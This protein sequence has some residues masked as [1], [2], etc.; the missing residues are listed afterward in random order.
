MKLRIFMLCILSLFILS[1]ESQPAIDTQLPKSVIATNHALTCDRETGFGLY[2][3]TANKTW[4]TWSGEDMNAYV[5]EYDHTLNTW[6]PVQVVGKIPN[7]TFFQYNWSEQKNDYHNY[8]KITQMANDKLLLVYSAHNSKLFKSISPAENSSKGWN[9]DHY[10]EIKSDGQPIHA[11]YPLVYSSDDGTVYI[12]YRYSTGAPTDYRPLEMLKSTD[13]GRTFASSVRVIDTHAQMADNLDEVYNDGFRHEPAHG[14]I[15]ERYL[16]GW[17]MAGGGLVNKHNI[18]HKNSYF[19]YF[20]PGSDTWAT[21]S[22][23][24]LGDCIDENEI[25]SCVVFDSGDIDSDN[26]MPIDYSFTAT[27]L[28]D[29]RPLFFYNYTDK[30]TSYIK[31]ALWTGEKWQ[32]VNMDTGRGLMDIEKIGPEEFLAY[33]KSGNTILVYK[34]T[35]GGSS[36]KRTETIKT[37]AKCLNKVALID[38]YHKDLKFFL[39]EADWTE[40]D[41]SGI[42]NV[43]VIGE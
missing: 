3:S 24:N 8:P 35:D 7:T 20:Y 27:Y 19:A 37:D 10:E 34:T 29:G 16:V 31:S 28:D 38:N 4:V 32:I 15:S 41:T 9:S 12:F 33:R 39:L 26:P 23:R 14:N 18:Y 17:T 40:R 25:A 36:W 11:T 42:Y 1:C 22:G 6:N 43:H 5:R 21:V 2:N 13:N 30:T